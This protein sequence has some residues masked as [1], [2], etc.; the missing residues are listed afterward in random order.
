MSIVPDDACVRELT[1][2]SN[3][4]SQYGLEFTWKNNAMKTVRLRIRG[5]DGTAPPGSN[6]ATGET[7]RV[8]I[9]RQYQDEAGKLFHEQ[10]HSPRSPNFNPDAANA[11]HIPWPK[12]FPGL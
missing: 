3:G 8:Q 11:T 9:G 12:Q 6:S 7:Y 5:P 4:G 1:P 10:V 2:H